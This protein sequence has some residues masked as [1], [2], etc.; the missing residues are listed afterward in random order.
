MKMREGESW[1]DFMVRCALSHDTSIARAFLRAL[2]VPV[3][4]SF[5]KPGVITSLDRFTDMESCMDQRY[6]VRL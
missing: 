4:R 1:H 6:G 3:P 5:P 2:G